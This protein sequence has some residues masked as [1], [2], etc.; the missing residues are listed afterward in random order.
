MTPRR[1][2]AQAAV[3]AAICAIAAGCGGVTVQDAESPAENTDVDPAK[4]SP[5][6]RT[7]AEPG[8]A[9]VPVEPAG[10]PAPAARTSRPD[11]EK[12]A[13]APERPAGQ[14]ESPAA[15]QPAEEPALPAAPGIIRLAPGLSIDRVNRHVDVDAEVCMKSGA[16]ELIATTPE[17]KTHESIFS[18][19]PRPR[20]V[21]VAL[22]MLGLQSGAPGQ[23]G[24][25]GATGDR[26]RIDVIIEKDGEETS[27][28]INEMVVGGE[29]GERLPANVFVFAG[30][31]L[32]RPK[33][34][35]RLV[36]VADVVGDVIS[37]V[38]FSDEVLALPE[39]ASSSNEDLVWRVNGSLVP[40]VGTRVVLRISPLTNEQ[41][42]EAVEAG[43][44]PPEEP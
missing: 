14:K 17:G 31:F 43:V 9:P 32:A 37:L 1:A 10:S 34:A 41:A 3:L 19:E 16:L 23:F 27:T 18:I 24:G 8:P 20:H 44:G 7:V 42:A 33:E 2:R 28:P 39:P 40:D 13:A 22:L 4:P 26:V 36:Y 11:P 29:A 15:A 5:P 25:F 35:E 21:H 30:S 12:R 6:V 38:S